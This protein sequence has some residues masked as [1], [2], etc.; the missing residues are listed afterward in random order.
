MNL[1]SAVRLGIALERVAFVKL[2]QVN[3]MLLLSQPAH[4]QMY[5]GE[6]MDED[7]RDSVRALMVRGKLRGSDPDQNPEKPE[8]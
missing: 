1:L 4:L 6:E 3:E 5:Y 2:E 8:S 7:Q